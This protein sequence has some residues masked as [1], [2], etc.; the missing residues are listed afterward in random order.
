MKCSEWMIH[1][2]FAKSHEP[3]KYKDLTVAQDALNEGLGGGDK[4]L[5]KYATQ[6]RF[7]KAYCKMSEAA[8]NKTGGSN[9]HTHKLL[10]MS[11]AI[12]KAFPGMTDMDVTGY[13]V[14]NHR[15]CQWRWVYDAKTDTGRIALIPVYLQNKMC[16]TD[17]TLEKF[18]VYLADWIDRMSGKVI[19]DIE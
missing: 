4:L 14:N 12:A 17:M 6:G 19:G 3:E 9:G 16:S 18:S 1:I 5:A 8:R 7:I 13:Y 11:K 15:T 10:K 2:G